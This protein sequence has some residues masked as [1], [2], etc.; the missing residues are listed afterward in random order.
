[1]VSSVHEETVHAGRVVAQLGPNL[2][3]QG[4]TCGK[5]AGSA[6]G[7]G[8]PYLRNFSLLLLRK[9][10]NSHCRMVDQRSRQPVQMV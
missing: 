8:R 1:M 5:V 7:H 2:D 3:T 9:L 4:D 6:S 10:M